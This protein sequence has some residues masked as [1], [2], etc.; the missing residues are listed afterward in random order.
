VLQEVEDV[1]GCLTKVKVGKQ[2]GSFRGHEDRGR[3]PKVSRQTFP[4]GHGV[5]T[6][7][8]HH[9]IAHQQSS[10]LM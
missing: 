10:A 2:R 6:D 1:G 7:M 4:G 5:N 3:E 9:L 8:C